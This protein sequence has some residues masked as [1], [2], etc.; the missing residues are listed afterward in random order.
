MKSQKLSQ[1]LLITT[2]ALLSSASV[3]AAE[4]VKVKLSGKE[5]VPAVE[6]EASGTAKITVADDHSVTGSI[7][8]KKIDGTAAHIHVGAPGENGPPIVIF[9]KGEEGKWNAPAGA[10]FNAEQY[11]AFKEGKLYINVHSAAH[12]PGEIRGQLKP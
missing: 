5:E 3:L 4:D 10:K 6:T 12:K 11:N 8:T 7:E 9:V 2:F 1:A